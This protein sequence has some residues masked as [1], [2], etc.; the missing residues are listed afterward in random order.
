MMKRNVLLMPGLTNMLQDRHV[1]HRAMA[2]VADVLALAKNV[3]VSLIAIFALTWSALLVPRSQLT[4]VQ[5][6]LVPNLIMLKTAMMLVRVNARMA[7]IEGTKVRHVMV[8]TQGV[9]LV[10]ARLLS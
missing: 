1:T 5:V 7:W 8:V 4:A 3:L 6:D 2:R 10:R 9:K